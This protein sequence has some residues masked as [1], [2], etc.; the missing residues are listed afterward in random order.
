VKIDNEYMFVVAVPSTTAI[1]VRTRGDQGTVAIGH[2]LLANVMTS[3]L[4]GDFPLAP[5]GLANLIPPSTPIVL[6]LGQTQTLVL[7]LQDTKFL[8]DKATAATITLPTP[9]K[10]ADGL[11]LTF[12]SQTAAAHIVSAPSL[13]ADGVTGSPH[14]TATFAAFKGCTVTLLV[15]QGLYN[16]E[17]Q[18]GVTV[19]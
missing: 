14:S 11:R 6:T 4:V 7:P 5:L 12:S 18:T 9:S 15:S 1:T 10:A 19:T 2:D 3:A 17:S 13:I 8:I 16:L